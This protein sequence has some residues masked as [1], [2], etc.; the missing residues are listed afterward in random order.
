MIIRIAHSPK[1]SKLWHCVLLPGCLHN[2]TATR[3]R[4]VGEPELP[5]L[6]IQV[7]A[8]IPNPELQRAAR[9]QG[10]NCGTQDT[11][12]PIHVTPLGH[13]VIPR[14]SASTGAE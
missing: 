12:T 2:T 14:V 5:K 1:S 11:M 8:Q 3:T 13:L 6:R 7:R 10:G 9:G 4:N